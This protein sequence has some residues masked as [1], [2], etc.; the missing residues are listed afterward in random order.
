MDQEQ[1]TRARWVCSPGVPGPSVTCQVQA[2]D[3]VCP[4]CALLAA[5]I[6]THGI[7]ASSSYTDDSKPTGSCTAEL[8]RP[9]P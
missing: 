8:C 7:L 4:F 3:V 5:P 1:L 6:P 2:H 9:A